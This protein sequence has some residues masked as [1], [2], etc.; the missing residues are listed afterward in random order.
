MNYSFCIK[1]DIVNLNLSTPHTHIQFLTIMTFATF[2]ELF[3][4]KLKLRTNGIIFTSDF[5]PNRKE[6]L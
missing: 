6:N 3:W 5:N 2:I 4:T 1:S